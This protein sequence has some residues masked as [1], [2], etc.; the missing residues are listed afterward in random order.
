MLHARIDIAQVL[1]MFQVSCEITEFHAGE[2]PTRWIERPVVL[3]LEE[4]DT[5]M[6]SLATV[7]HLLTLWSERTI[8]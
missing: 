5:H 3:T 2:D 6:D 4:P 7:I 1:D 8:S